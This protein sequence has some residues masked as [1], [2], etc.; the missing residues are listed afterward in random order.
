M[1]GSLAV[2]VNRGAFQTLTGNGSHLLVQL[3][4]G[5]T[6]TVLIA[7]EPTGQLC[8]IT[9]GTGTISSA[10]VNNIAI[11]CV[12]QYTIS[13][14]VS[15]LVGTVVLQ[16]NGGD[17][18]TVTTN[19][20]LPFA[21]KIAAGGTYA[22]TVF[23]QPATQTCTVTAGG[24]TAT[25]NETAIVTCVSQYTISAQVSGLVGTLVLQDNGGNNLT[26]MTNGTSAFTTTIAA[27]AAY[28]V[29]VF[30]QPASQICTVTAGAGT[31]NANETAVVTCV[32][33]YTI[34]ATVSG[35]TGTVVLQDNGGN[36][37][38]VTTNGTSAFTNKIAAG[39]AYAVTVFTQPATQNCSV[40]MGAGT[41][42]A[43]ETAVVTCVSQYTI[44]ANVSGLNG[45][46]LVLQ[47]N[48]GNNLAISGNG[49]T[50]FTT[51]IASGGA[52]AVTVFAQPTAPAQLCSV[53][54]PASGTASANTTVQVVCVNVGKYVFVANPLDGAAGSVAAFTIAPATGALMPVTGSPFT[55]GS[56]EVA[57]AGLAI[58]SDNNQY[59]YVADSGSADVSTWGIG[60]GGVLAPDAV[61]AS[62][63]STGTST[64]KPYSV[65]FDPSG[66]LYVGSADS[67][68]GTVE[69]YSVD[70]GALSALSGSPYASGNVPYSLAL[71][72]ADKFLYAPN[73]NDGRVSEYTLVSGAPSGLI[74][75]PTL[76]SPYAV[77]VHPTGPYVYITDNGVNGGGTAN[78]VEEYTYD[79]SSGMLTPENSYNVGLTPQGIAI[80]PTG[81]FLYVSNSGDGT[82]SA[83]TINPTTGALT[84][85][86][87]SPFTASGT[88][89]T[90]TPT[91]LAIDPSSQFLYVANGDALTIS[92]FTITAGTGVL[93]PGNL[94]VQCTNGAGGP[95]AIVVQ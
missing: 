30:A 71:D 63:A 56:G 41:A 95:Q 2:Q 15:G 60:A 49:T 52:Y 53:A 48:G 86:A 43:N 14:Q 89:S 85:I 75:S 23:T 10:P 84:A 68:A 26:V 24:G 81:S 47:D 66:Y 44:S 37:L 3:P 72:P 40:T 61:M 33:Q 17:N 32:S 87:G 39:G 45:T 11:T 20:T 57:P 38:T 58:D 21:T 22:V 34:S 25:A 42:N 5:S 7:T 76:A 70:A 69:G 55:P 12:S 83:F 51:K 27:G 6:Y 62:P 19:G 91:A 4:N 90:V 77:A 35:L 54:A 92:V 93:V 8:T 18:L 64:N 9:N 78:T 79:A 31:A 74:Y 67:P 82:V 46:G 36:N 1:N 80:D 59:L 29:T 28:A 88:A 13:A 94:A 73:V 16:D 50:A 65:A